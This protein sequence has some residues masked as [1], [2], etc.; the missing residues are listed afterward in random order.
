MIKDLVLLF[1]NFLALGI[2]KFTIKLIFEKE[3]VR[4]KIY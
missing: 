4:N 1:R 2:K 3:C